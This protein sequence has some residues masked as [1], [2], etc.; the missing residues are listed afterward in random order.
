MCIRDRGFIEF[1]YAHRGR[2]QQHL[3]VKFLGCQLA[4]ALGQFPGA[5][6][7]LPQQFFVVIVQH[8]FCPPRT[9]DI[10]GGSAI[11]RQTTQLIPQGQSVDLDPERSISGA[12]Q[13]NL[14]MMERLLFRQCVFKG[15]QLWLRTRTQQFLPGLARRQRGILSQSPA[16]FKKASSG[17]GLPKQVIGDA[18]KIPVSQ[19][20]PLARVYRTAEPQSHQSDGEHYNLCLLYTSRCV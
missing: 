8:R 18:G 14:Q 3:K 11:S 13:R 19:R 17:I 5:F 1:Q 2:G 7:H 12:F 9:G 16:R 15:H 20:D 10:D 4:I 6:G